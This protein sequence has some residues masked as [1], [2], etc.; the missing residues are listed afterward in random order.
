MKNA[1]RLP[2]TALL[3][4]AFSL[5]VASAQ[6]AADILNKLDAAQ[7]TVKDLSFRLAGTATLDGSPQKI[8][9]KVQSIPSAALA[10]VVFAAPDS[11]ADNI[12][13][14]SK[15]EVK[16]YLYLTNQVT[17]TSTSKAAG[18]AGMTGLD[19][20]QVS[21]FSSFLKAYDVKLIATSGAV[22]NHL[23]T[24]EG[25]PKTS[26]VNDGKARVF[27]SETGWR[28]TRLQLLDSASKVMAD[29]NISDYKVNSGLTAARLTQLPKDVEVIRQ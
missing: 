10:R 15:N 6:T 12:L 4:G 21:N 9:L 20:T 26:G 1:V 3:L 25:T 16:N 5:N 29:L 13:V 27:V 28:P 7:K 2:L 22:G 18:N 14:V 24:L 23:Y 19:L 8:D 11:L 17:V